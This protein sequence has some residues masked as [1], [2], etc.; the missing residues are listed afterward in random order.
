MRFSFKR[1]WATFHVRNKEFWRD[2]GAVGWTFLFPILVVLAFGYMFNLDG[3]GTY[4][5]GYF[6]TKPTDHQLIQWIK[7]EDKSEALKKLKGQLVDLV[8]DVNQTPP[9][10]YVAKDSIKS[11]VAK[12]VW[13]AQFSPE[14]PA[15]EE[16]VQGRKLRYI[17]WLFPGLLTVNVLWM[18]LWGVGWVIV[19]QR[20][21]GV[22]K[23]FKASPLTPLE[24]LLAQMLSRLVILIVTGV[25]VFS[26]SLMIYPFQV[27]GSYGAILVMYILGCLALSSMGLIVAARFTSEEFANGILNLFMYPMMFLGEVWFSLE[28]S[29]A[30][31]Y[32]I[33]KGNPLWHMTE[34]IRKIMN[35]GATL[36]ELAPSL[37][38]L[39]LISVVFT[40]IGS[41]TFKWTKD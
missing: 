24:Y 38:I 22:L 21:I 7:Y 34:G 12:T 27:E 18:A 8:V 3:E 19:R 35:E 1:V 14:A 16:Q 13:L 36:L 39:A 33:A 28:G 30:W 40:T 26:G 29:P 31:V 23:R 4:K 20:K 9:R 32:L 5:A 37:I 41:L 6:G 2:K 25:I 10:Y 17:D 15:V 11:D